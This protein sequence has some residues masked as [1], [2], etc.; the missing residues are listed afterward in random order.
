M[1]SS[2]D[3]YDLITLEPPPPSAAGVVNL[4]SPDFYNLARSR[5]NTNGILAQWWPL[6]TQNDEDSRALVRS[7]VD[8][9]PYASVWTTELHEMLLVGSREP[10]ELDA[11]RIDA[12]FDHREVVR[13]MREVGIDSPS[14]LLATWITDRDG[15]LRYAGDASPVTDDRPSKEYATWVRRGEFARVLP[16]VLAVQ[17]APPIVGANTEFLKDVERQHHSL[18]QFHDAGLAASTGDRDR[19]SRQLRSAM[20]TE[21]GN[22]YFRWIAGDGLSR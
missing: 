16:A 20:T 14:A 2:T 3:R 11:R 15:L 19:W 18:M 21:P 4:Y 13:A 9:F 17:T 8:A 10:M 12:R 5:L 6:P 1:Q 22:L 7:F